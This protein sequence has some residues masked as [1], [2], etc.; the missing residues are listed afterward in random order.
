MLTEITVFC[1]VL[2]TLVASSA[3]TGVYRPD[4]VEEGPQRPVIAPS[5]PQAANCFPSL[6]FPMPNATPRTLDGWWCDQRDE[7]AF[8]G[9]SYEVTECESFARRCDYPLKRIYRPKS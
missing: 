5:F 4:D 9:F 8:L 2:Y 1:I 6:G 7:Y 3:A